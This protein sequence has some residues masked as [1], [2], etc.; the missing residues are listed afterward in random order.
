MSSKK[1]KKHTRANQPAG[2]EMPAEAPMAEPSGETETDAVLQPK[3]KK[4]ILRSVLEWVVIIICA[5]ACSAFI[6]SF[7]VD[8]Y[9]IPTESMTNTIVPGDRVFGEKI[10][11]K[12]SSPQRGDV[13]TFIDP[14]GGKVTYVKR[15]IA[16]AGDTV[17]LINGAVYI[18]GEYQDEDYTLG[19]PSYPLIPAAEAGDIKFPYTVPEGTIWVMGDNRTNSNDSRYFGPVPLENIAAKGICV[20]WPTN[21]AHNL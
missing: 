10:T 9:I 12:F 5:L 17:D 19:R 3:R 11:Y 16:V 20:F 15:C 2:M 1:S 8:V 4:A 21:R 6:R 18:N 7:I 13:V 14:I